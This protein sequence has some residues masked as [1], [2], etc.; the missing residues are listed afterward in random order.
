MKYLLSI[1]LC[2]FA[3]P[4]ISQQS[5]VTL[6][7][8]DAELRS[9]IEDVALETHKTFI[10]DPQVNGKVNLISSEPISGDLLFETLLSVLK[11]NGMAAVPTSGGAYK[12]V[13]S[14]QALGD[15][16]PVNQNATGDAL[17]TR[18]F[19]IKHADPMTISAAI[20]PYIARNGSNFAR[21]G[22][23]MVVVT[24]HADNLI[25]IAQI[26]VSLDADQTVIRTLNLIHTSP[27]EMAEIA[28][29]L[30]SQSA[31][32]GEAKP[33]LQTIPVRGSNSLILKGMPE[34]LDQYMPI[35]ADIDQNNASRG[36]MRMIRLKYATTDK[37]VPV[38]Q[39][40]VDAMQGEDQNTPGKSGNNDVTIAEFQGTNS[41]VINAGPEMQQRLAD[42]INQLDIPQDQVLVEAIVVEVSE[43]ASKELGLQYV[44]AGGDSS[45]IPFTVAN[46]S[47][48]A[49]NILAATGAIVVN[50]GDSSSGTSAS[51]ILKAAAV[52][53]FLG[54]DGFAIGAAGRRSD[55][56]VFGVIL[57]ALA[58]DTD[59]NI[60]STPSVMALNNESA[61]FLAGQEIPI[62][63]GEALGS[64][65]SNP[66]R[67]IERKNVGI[68]LD[69][70]PQINDNNEIRL[71]I[72]Q[73][74]S[75]I[76]GPVSANSSELVTNKR[77]I[78]T[79]VRVNDGEIIVI[80]GLIQQNERI[81]VDKVP[82]LGDIPLLGNAFKSEGKTRDNTNL[83]IFLRPTI[84][85]DRQDRTRVTNNKVNYMRERQ[86][87]S[88]SKLSIDDL[89][90]NV[91]ETY[92][93]PMSDDHGQ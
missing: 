44:L 4:A 83:M 85:R 48:S 87:V 60:L 86:V 66:F 12:I 22:L 78:Q 79:T 27:N 11:V 18:V 62:T 71:D 55:G 3:L 17:V 63:T 91:I 76:S 47:N 56:G 80:G 49:P 51:D 67:T 19:R 77:E 65:N 92:K 43:N 64:A 40:L 57:N 59:S 37:M 2:L 46:Y 82:L 39:Q 68:Q 81:S 70:K 84:V 32:N 74:V 29:Q 5:D 16:G 75:S 20:K 10:I 26:I 35:L 58:S 1:F 52:D 24:D 53:S 42:V 33:L 6:N 21:E 25:R 61:T 50:D 93:K 41:L 88:G 30:T 7:Y 28:T 9:F 36:D 90:Q 14:E 8:Q 31:F 38:L 15:G 13:K 72:R 45:N 73:E 69:I 89:L 54:L 34:V 23:P